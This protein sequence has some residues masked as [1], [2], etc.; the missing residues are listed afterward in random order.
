M[1]V[2][3]TNFNYSQDL[4]DPNSQTF[5]S[6][7]DHF[8]REIKK[9]YGSVPGYEGVKII[10]LQSGSVVVGHRVFFTMAQSGNTT[11]N[12]R[13]TTEELVEKLREAAAS[14]GDCRDNASVLCLV[15]RPNPVVSAMAETRELDGESGVEPR[16]V[17]LTTGITPLTTSLTTPLTTRITR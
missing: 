9:I 7:Q 5:V 1:E 15:L 4:K 13:E 3:V 16:T 11:E 14:Q 10:S 17:P 6:F 12:F 2:T 8:S